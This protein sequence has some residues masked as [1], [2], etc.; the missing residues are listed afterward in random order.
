MDESLFFEHHREAPR[1]QKLCV[2]A[3]VG[4]SM[5]LFAA[6]SLEESFAASVVT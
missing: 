6:A 3:D 5:V 4:S 1:K 2:F